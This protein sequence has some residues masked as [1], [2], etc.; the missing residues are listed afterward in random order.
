M[1]DSPNVRRAYTTPEP[2]PPDAKPEE[3]EAPSSA[4]PE[5]P[6]RRRSREL[7]SRWRGDGLQRRLPPSR[8]SLSRL[9]EI[10]RD[11]ARRAAARGADDAA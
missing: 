1:R 10:L 6:P 7:G 11:D 5:K 8:I 3:P 9:E 4:T 2:P